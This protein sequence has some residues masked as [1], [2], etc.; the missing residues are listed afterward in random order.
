MSVLFSP[1]GGVTARIVS[2]IGAGKKSVDAASYSFTS[3]NISDA[4]IAKAKRGTPVRVL[5]D[6]TQTSGT[7]ARIHDAMEAAGAA[8]ANIQVRLYSPSGG[9]MHNKFLITDGHLAETGSFNYTVKA[10]LAN[11]ENAVFPATAGLS[12]VGYQ[13]KLDSAFQER[14]NALW[15]L[16]KAEPRSLR[17]IRRF[18]RSMTR[19]HV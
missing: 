12:D 10:E 3:T 15:A 6:K 13:T 5:M 7:Q 14:F 8:G 4:L 16:A 11:C 17:T 18:V 9:I 19:Q 2:L 1:K